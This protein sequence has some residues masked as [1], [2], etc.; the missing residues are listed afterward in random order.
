MEQPTARVAG[1]EHVTVQDEV[2]DKTGL[3]FAANL[4]EG[5]VPAAVIE[6][7]VANFEPNNIPL[8]L[9]SSHHGRS[10]EVGN[11]KK[12]TALW[13]D[14]HGNQYTSLSYK[15]NNFTEQDIIPSATAPSRFIPWGLQEDDALLRVV[16]SSRLLRENDIPT[17]WI[18]G[19]TE[20]PVIAYGAEPVTQ[21][22]YKKR[23]V[24]EALG[25]WPVAEAAKIA[26]AITPMT[27]FV[28]AR[29]ME[30][31]DRPM[32]FLDDQTP[33]QIQQ[34]LQKVFSV[35]NV[36]HRSD[37]D[38]RELSTDS[39]EDCRYY[40]INLLPKLQAQN[41][42]RLHNLEL[43]HKFPTPGNVTAL[44]G[45]IDLDSI[46]GEPLGFGDKPITFRDIRRDI[47]VAFDGDRT[48]IL[49]HV[50]ET[51][52]WFDD[53]DTTLHETQ[54]TFLDAYLENRSQKLSEQEKLLLLVE[55]KQGSAIPSLAGISEQYESLQN[56]LSTY[57]QLCNPVAKD[58]AVLTKQTRQQKLEMAEAYAL[59]TLDTEYYEKGRTN[60]ENPDKLHLELIAFTLRRIDADTRAAVAQQLTS[61]HSSEAFD[62]LVQS[63]EIA[64]E[65]EHDLRTTIASRFAAAQSIRNT[66]TQLLD[67]EKEHYAKTIQ[68]ALNAA[69]TINNNRSFTSLDMEI[70]LF[71]EDT[72]R[73]PLPLHYHR[74]L[75]YKILPSVALQTLLDSLGAEDPENK[76]Q[77]HDNP[78]DMPDMK[79][80]PIT[81]YLTDAS[82]LRVEKHITPEGEYILRTNPS[83][84][85][86]YIAG[87]SAED[88]AGV[89]HVLLQ[90]KQ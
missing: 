60:E 5:G 72:E 75:P 18:V 66:K 7:A 4:F 62:T 39:P 61:G 79:T 44:G 21:A 36:T 47:R 16:K 15:G 27:F 64:A 81:Q 30:I 42:A 82:I 78:D 83:P 89:T 80:L 53:T 9:I 49:Q 87:V 46:H 68:A 2:I 59:R 88:E 37:T 3:P 24:A 63:L 70:M 52:D 22:E 17:E 35:Y 45:V 73:E 69:G 19:V 26:K 8:D 57:E 28:T 56:A 84:D 10:Y 86:T 1:W 32:D 14:R 11:A 77:I 43:V 76:V 23:L 6:E 33:E 20:P 13:Q 71:G 58:T 50:A 90:G 48:E 25:K 74:S 29:C 51:T 85:M 12:I 40:F 31:N 55:I 41:L 38:S 65:T 67:E 54:L 34:R